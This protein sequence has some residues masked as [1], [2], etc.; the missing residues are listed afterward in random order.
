[1]LD[2]EYL[3]LVNEKID[4]LYCLYI[5]TIRPSWHFS[6]IPTLHNHVHWP[7]PT[8]YR[9]GSFCSPICHGQL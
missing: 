1:M 8:K 3:L 6:S 4:K 2:R 5:V 9:P 7:W